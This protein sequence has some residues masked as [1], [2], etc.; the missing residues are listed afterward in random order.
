MWNA[1]FQLFDVDAEYIPVDVPK[2][3]LRRIVFA[4][5]DNQKVRGFNVTVPYKKSVADELW[6]YSEDGA[7]VIGNVNTVHKIGRAGS[8]IARSTDGY[9]AISSIEELCGSCHMT[10]DQNVAVIGAGG[11]GS[12]IAVACAQEGAF[13]SLINRTKERAQRLEERAAQYGY[14]RIKAAGMYD[15]I[16]LSQE[17][18]DALRS[19][20]VIINTIDVEKKDPKAIVLPEDIFVGDNKK[21]FMDI[22]YGHESR[23]LDFAKKHGHTAVPGEWMLLHQAVKAFQYAYREEVQQR[24]LIASQIAEPMRFALTH[25]K[26]DENSEVIKR[27]V[28]AAAAQLG[29]GRF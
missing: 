7:K 4:L 26:F 22:V 12:A 13:V 28:K 19:A 16:F 11:S 25:F 8:I 23:F 24:G 10:K 20:H 17:A 1:A 29:Q 15:G 5:L 3:E 27:E 6:N 2:E 21:I 9:G 14:L 18:R